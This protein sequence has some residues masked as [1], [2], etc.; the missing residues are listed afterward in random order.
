MKKA[1]ILSLVCLLIFSLAGC[2]QPETESS[3]DINAE[4]ET[5]VQAADGQTVSFYGWGGNS[6][7]NDWIDNV[8]ARTVKE[9]YNITLNRVPMNIDEVLAKLAAEK[10]AGKKDGSIDMIWI[11]G[12]NF[13]S[14]KANGLLFGPFADKLPN[15]NL[16][17]DSGK[18]G[19]YYDS[20]FPIEGY[21]APYGKAQFVFTADLAVT[22]DTPKN[23]D[24]FMEFAKDNQGKVTYPALPDFTGSAFVRTIVHDLIGYD[25]LMNAGADKEKVR[26]ILQPVIAYLTELNPYLWNEGKTF[27]ATL[28]QLDNM[29]AD[30]EL[31]L[32]MNYDPYAVIL[33]MENGVYTDSCG[34]F[35]FEN[36]TVGNT[37]FI[38]IAANSPNKAAAV[39]VINEILTPQMQASKYQAVKLLP[40]I[41]NETLSDEEKALFEAVD[42]GEGALDQSYLLARQV[43]ELPADLWPIIEEIWLEE[44]V[45]K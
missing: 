6:E 30:G 33:N 32:T 36:G 21:E 42:L 26:Q 35:I 23:A 1:I 14:A 17:V 20:G 27:P 2:G 8:L 16:Y 10:Q 18:V 39:A 12:E 29:F 28:G 19:N 34:S 41:D 7:L 37:N 44:V 3:F 13:Y 22:P 5:I 25:E 11:N 40:A 15:Y 9:E 24:E 4:F 45:G 38:A 43:P 31:C